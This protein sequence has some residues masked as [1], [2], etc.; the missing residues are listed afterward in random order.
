MPEHD[1]LIELFP[2]ESGRAP[3]LTAYAVTFT[4]EATA[5]RLGDTLARRMTRSFPGRWV[6][7]NFRLITDTP[8]SPAQLNISLDVL[9]NDYAERYGNLQTVEEDTAWS[10]TPRALADF[11]VKG[12]LK[13]LRSEMRDVLSSKGA[14]IRNGYV[15][16]EPDVRPWITGNQA[17]LSIS[18]ESHLLHDRNLQQVLASMDDSGEGVGL[19][20]MVRTAASTPGTVTR[21][22]G[23]LGD[24]RERLVAQTDSKGL[25]RYLQH[26]DD[27]E[28]VVQMQT[29]SGTLDEYPASALR[30][31]IRQD[32]PEDYTRFDVRMDAAARALALPAAEQVRLVQMVSGILKKKGIIGNA[33]N[34]RTDPAYFAAM[35]FM[36]GLEFANGRSRPFNPKQLVDDFTQNGVNRV[37][38]RF[39]AAPV[40]MALINT[41]DSSLVADF[42]EAMRRQI[43][44]TFGFQF[45]I[46]RERSVRVV[47][48]TNIASAVRAVEKE[49]PDVVLAFF[50]DDAGKSA[51]YA[52]YLKSLT[53]GKGIASQ[54]VYERTIH[55]PEEMPAVVMGL[56]A[57]T[58]NVPYALAEPL[59]YADV[60]VGLDLVREALSWGDRVVALARIYRAD[61]SFYCYRMDDI[62]LDSGDAVPFVVLQHLFPEEIFGGRRVI[63]HHD[64]TLPDDILHKMSRW[65]DILR[66]DFYPVEILRQM[67]PRLYGLS[68]GVQPPPWGSIF[69][70]NDRETF[71]VS[72][73]PGLDVQAR[74]LHVRV[75]DGSLPI[76]QAVYSVL[77]WTLLHYT[78]QPQPLPVTIKHADDMAQWLARGMFPEKKEGHVPFWL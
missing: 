68:D 18:I 40:R 51:V 60:V 8:A 70:L 39:E 5:Q 59:E 29:D 42:T 64:G 58:G 50:P 52:D 53:L 17:T 19:A 65:A 46:A 12:V 44:N 43:E 48:E 73:V 38:E 6:W 16:R 72:A 63:V 41:L 24:E 2:V 55:D 23:H 47:S 67:V 31:V 21:I 75:P 74:P 15:L 54:A 45:E 66:A 76:E 11:V 34:S 30:V 61:G 78:P 20:V 13:P 1:L 62:E 36:P 77:A 27:S 49:N 26:A 32:M 3:D 71:A 37:H 33:F 69:Q 56:L 9:R 4:D 35:D 57:K 7:S 28:F 10:M 22:V 14:R 25:K